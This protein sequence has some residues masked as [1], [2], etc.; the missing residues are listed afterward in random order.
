MPAA[1]SGAASCVACSA[2]SCA[3]ERDGRVPP[4]CESRLIRDPIRD[5]RYT[6]RNRRRPPI[7]SRPPATA[8][9]R[10]VPSETPR[11]YHARWAEILAY[12]LQPGPLS[13]N[14]A[15]AISHLVAHIPLGF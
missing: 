8:T 13:T 2:R 7:V 5:F 9:T 3:N 12:P 14:V 6:I 11:P 1:S 4:D 15:L 10:P